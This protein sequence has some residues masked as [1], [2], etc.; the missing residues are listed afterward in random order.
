MCVCVI[1]VVMLTSYIEGQKV[2]IFYFSG[3]RGSFSTRFPNRLHD[4]V[5][6][7][8]LLLPGDEFVL[9]PLL[10]LMSNSVALGTGDVKPQRVRV[11][12]QSV[13][14]EFEGRHFLEICAS[15][16]EPIVPMG[17][18]TQLKTGSNRVR[19][20]PSPQNFTLPPKHPQKR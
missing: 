11:T 19:A 8:W 12:S 18:P 17:L 2:Y 3:T 1:Q 7:Q 14:Q 6:E 16:F 20:V 9:L 5:W 4:L 10:D 13:S 15:N